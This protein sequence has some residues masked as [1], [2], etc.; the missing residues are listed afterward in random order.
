MRMLTSAK[1][2]NPARGR[3]L[4]LSLALVIVS[5]GSL[6]PVRAQ[7]DVP[8]PPEITADAAYALDIDA[9][10]PLYAKNPDEEL[11]PAS[12]TKIATALVVVQNSEMTEQVLIEEGDLVNTDEFSNM[13]LV[14]GD[15][16]IVEQL[17]YGLLLPSGND[18]AKALARHVGGALPGGEDEPVGAF[19]QAMNDLVAELGLEHTNFVNPAGEDAENHYSSAHDLAVLGGELLDVAT[20]ATIVDTETYETQSV[21]PEARLYTL[22]TTNNLLNEDGI[23]GIKTGI[24][25]KAGGCLVTGAIYSANRVVIVVLGSDTSTDAATGFLMSPARYDDSLAIIRAIFNDY[26][27]V[28]PADVEGLADAMAAWRVTLGEDGADITV[29]TGGDPVEFALRLGPEGSPNDEVG[30]VVFFVGDRQ[31]AERPLFQI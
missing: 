28:S 7:D 10:Q 11:A 6:A 15:T 31:I 26:Q 12:T 16:L 22:F 13:G 29:P 18:A 2:W 27:W 9:V 8:A 3:P 1:S 17:L 23:I 21:G 14:A 30:S 20:L 24:T 25:E 4:W 19:V 5:G